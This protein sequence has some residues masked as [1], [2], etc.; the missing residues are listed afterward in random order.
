MNYN[1][2]VLAIDDDQDILDIFTSVLTRVSHAQGAET[3]ALSALLG[4]TP[5]TVETKRR[6]FVVDTAQQ[7]EEGFEMIKA[8]KASGNNY[9]VVFIDMRMPPGWDG[10]TTAREIRQIDEMAEIIVVT[11]YSDSSIADI[12]EQVGFTDRL[13]YLKKPFDD[14]EILQL[15]DSLTMRWNLER[16]VHGLASFLEN[17]I[18]S[19]I[20]LNIAFNNEEEVTPFLESTLK[21]IGAFL[22]TPDVFLACIENEKLLM[23][24]GL[25]RFSDGMTN[26]S[27]FKVMV[28]QIL[29]KEPITKIFR[30]D[31]FV[32]MPF[33]CK[34]YHGVVVG[35]IYEVEVEGIDRLL[36]VLAKNM[37]RMFSTGETMSDLRQQIDDYKQKVNTLE[38]R[39]KLLEND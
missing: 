29:K 38:A 8:A 4:I 23:K 10:V 16:K 3:V 31:D 18:D 6:H 12:V 22:E 24:I 25:G 15:A 11:A 37:A 2:R 5:K 21:S 39:M 36:A 30:I 35:A 34:Q 9:A 27:S 13:L 7:G 17:I 1:N 14:E 32:I 26:G 28:D 20:S 19:L 33:A